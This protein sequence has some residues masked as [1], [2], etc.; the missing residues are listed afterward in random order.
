VHAQ[1][2][3]ERYLAADKMIVRRIASLPHKA[4][5]DLPDLPHETATK[6]IRYARWLKERIPEL[7]GEG[8]V[9][10]LYLDLKGSIGELYENNLG[11]VLGQIY[12]LEL[13][14]EPFPL[15]IANPVILE[16][17][18][19]QL[20]SLQTLRR[21]VEFRKMSVQL[22]ADAWVNTL[23]DVK[24]FVEAQ[25]ADMIHLRTPDLGSVHHTVE[26]VQAC[27][28]GGV[29]VLLGGSAAETD[30]SAR[31]TVHVAL[32]TR[33]ELLMA[34]PGLGVDEAIMF[35]QNEMARTLAA[36]SVGSPP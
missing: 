33:P 1:T 12:A 4:M 35:V 23:S 17:R 22:V 32:A 13:S 25:A 11:R 24:A 10:T 34:K 6:L 20:E 8:Y 16:S 26:A 27:Q 7:A 9:P 36:L 30:L 19:A 15:R 14:V 29:Q 2:G 21:Y 18:E 28:A 3:N 5:D 31:V